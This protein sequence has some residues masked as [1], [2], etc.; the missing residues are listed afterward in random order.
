MIVAVKKQKA[1]QITSILHEF[2]IYARRDKIIMATK[3]KENQLT[4]PL[5]L[6][7]RITIR[8]FMSTPKSTF[9][10]SSSSLALLGYCRKRI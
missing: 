3:Q 10:G 6:H 5:P 2:R 8:E 1:A 9:F 7:P 4:L